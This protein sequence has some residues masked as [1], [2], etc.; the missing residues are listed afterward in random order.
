MKFI[1]SRREDKGYLK[2]FSLQ[3]P[4]NIPL[5]RALFKKVIA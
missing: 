4:L 2:P 3:P 5:R 1:F